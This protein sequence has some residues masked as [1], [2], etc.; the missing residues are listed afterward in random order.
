M[1]LGSTDLSQDSVLSMHVEWFLIWKIRLERLHLTRWVKCS[2][3]NEN[4]K[5]DTWCLKSQETWLHC[6]C[7]QKRELAEEAQR[8]GSWELVMAQV[9]SPLD[10]LDVSFCWLPI[11][12]L[13][14]YDTLEK[15]PQVRARV[16]SQESQVP[17]VLLSL[18]LRYYLGSTLHALWIHV[19]LWYFL[20]R[21][22]E[23]SRM[24]EGSASSF[25]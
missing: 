16:S 6:V 21:L 20:P 22:W 3:E 17:P 24:C 8:F 18:L 13:W 1:G 15:S 23:Y 9:G 5:H 2:N 12:G 7:L 25:G 19:M 10:C 4:A 11:H 14:S